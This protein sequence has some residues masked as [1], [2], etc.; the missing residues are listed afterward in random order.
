MSLRILFHVLLVITWETSARTQAFVISQHRKIENR[1]LWRGSDADAFS[2]VLFRSQLIMS[3]KKKRRRKGKPVV[4]DP[5]N[6]PQTFDNDIL[7]DVA[8]PESSTENEQIDAN[9]LDTD[10]SD[11]EYEYEY[12]DEED[13]GMELD[14][15]SRVELALGIAPTKAR[16]SLPVPSETQEEA[17]EF[18]PSAQTGL[19]EDFSSPVYLPSVEA[20]EK[21]TQARQKISETPAKQVQSIERKNL[22]ELRDRLEMD[23]SADMLPET[24]IENYDFASMLLGEAG[25]SFFGVI[26]TGPLQA[27][28]LVLAL[29][30][31]L[32]AFAE[33]PGNPLTDLPPELRLFLKEGLALTYGI[34][35]VLAALGFFQAGSKGLPVVFWTVKC[36]LLG[37]IA[38][39]EVNRAPSK[40]SRRKKQ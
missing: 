21:R 5:S 29:I 19:P 15:I 24:F 17:S 31:L 33:D 9:E 35:T 25:K 22:K 28:H 11:D 13:E 16:V 14:V 37:G 40:T 20:L 27:G 26:P 1:C 8:S 10:D 12:V 23:P 7:E 36:W 4:E 39:D 18:S 38:F 2:P 30:C 34:N 3:A 6:L 32:A